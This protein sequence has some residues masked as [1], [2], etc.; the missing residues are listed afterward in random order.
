MIQALAILEEC[1]S[2][3]ILIFTETH[4][5]HQQISILDNRLVFFFVAR[6][7]K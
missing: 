3:D 1:H 6:G 4:T 7:K 2:T 5:L